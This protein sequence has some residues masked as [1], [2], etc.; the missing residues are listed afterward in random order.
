MTQILLHAYG[1]NTA[2]FQY[3]LF[4]A[5]FYLYEVIKWSDIIG[6]CVHVGGRWSWLWEVV[7]VVVG[8]GE[9]AQNVVKSYYAL[10]L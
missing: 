5:I 4:T 3:F 7:V 1:F 6:V 9:V 10:I 8:G 2:A